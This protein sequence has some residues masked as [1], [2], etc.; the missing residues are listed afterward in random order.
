LLPVT[1]SIDFATNSVRDTSLSITDA[2]QLLKPVAVEGSLM[3]SDGFETRHHK[4]SARSS[5][6]RKLKSTTIPISQRCSGRAG[7]TRRVPGEQETTGIPC[8][9][10]PY[11]V[12][13]MD[14]GNA[15][16][17]GATPGSKGLD[18][19]SGG[20]SGSGGGGANCPPNFWLDGAPFHV[21][22]PSGSP[23]SSRWYRCHPFAA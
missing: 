5:P 13:I 15:G 19:F 9:P 8:F 7:N 10:S 2:A 1:A 4:G 3:E 20:G 22:G 18:R 6:N 12:S 21:S 16:T 17:S 23:I 11:F 14:Y